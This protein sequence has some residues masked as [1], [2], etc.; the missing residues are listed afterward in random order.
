MSNRYDNTTQ[1]SLKH[2]RIVNKTKCEH[3]N[4]Q[5]VFE[6]TADSARIVAP[7]LKDF[8]PN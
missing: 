1:N 7:S 6:T 4:E 3:N 8:V 2:I 5:H